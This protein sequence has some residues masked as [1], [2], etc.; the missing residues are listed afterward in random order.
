MER[1][2]PSSIF[3]SPISRSSRARAKYARLT[4]PLLHAAHISIGKVT[5]QNALCLDVSNQHLLNHADSRHMLD[6]ISLWME[7]GEE[8]VRR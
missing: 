3:G 7:P 4:A 5:K 6:R 1:L 8:L 2:Q